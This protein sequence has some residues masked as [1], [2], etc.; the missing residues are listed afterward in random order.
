MGLLRSGLQELGEGL[1]VVVDGGG[2][3]RFSHA[4]FIK[5]GTQVRFDLGPHGAQRSGVGRVQ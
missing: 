5:H 1:G 4:E 2:D 3:H